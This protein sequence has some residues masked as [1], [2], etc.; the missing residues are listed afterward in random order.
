VTNAASGIAHIV[1]NDNEVSNPKDERFIGSS[2]SAKRTFPITR[3][4]IAPIDGAMKS[5]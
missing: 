1:A 2:T 5:S 3:L 4:V